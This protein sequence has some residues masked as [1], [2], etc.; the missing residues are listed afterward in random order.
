MATSLTA[1][2]LPDP[3]IEP[4]MTVPR[5]GKLVYGLGRAASYNA[6]TRGELPVIRVGSR[7]LVPTAKLREQLGLPVSPVRR[8]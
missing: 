8:D 2:Q 3:E 7:L 5:A 1:D 6:A 4:T